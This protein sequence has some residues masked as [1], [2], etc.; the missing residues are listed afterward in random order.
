VALPRLSEQL[1]ASNSQLQWIVDGYTLVYAGL[2]LTSGSLGDRFGRKGAL[3]IGL[4]TFGI[5]SALSAFAT[6]TGMLIA[7][8]SLMGVGAALIMPGTLSIMTNIFTEPKERARAIGIWA[9]VAA[10]GVAIGPM[11][12]GFLIQHFWWGSVFLVNV[13]VVAVAFVAGR[14]ILPTSK[15]P[16][17]P[18]LDPIGAVLSIAALMTLLWGLIEAPTRGWGSTTIVGA[19]VAGFAML[20]CFIL[21]ELHSSHP[22][23][24][25]RFFRNRRFTAANIA[26][27][28]VFFALFGA[29]FLITQ[30]LQFVLGYSALKAGFALMPIALPMLVLGPI[31]ARIVEKLGTKVVVT[32]GLLLVSFGLFLLTM[33]NMG[34]GY[35]D[36]VIPMVILATGMGLTMAPATESIMGS[37]PRSKAGIGSAMNDTTR[38]MGGALGVAVIGSVL[39][40]VYRPHATAN[41]KHTV[42]AAHLHGQQA[43]QAHQAVDAIRDQIGAAYTVVDRAGLAHTAAGNQIIDA[44]R[45]A[46]VDGFGGAVM[47]GAVVA[48]LGALVT[49]AFLPARAP[50]ID[51]AAEGE[52]ERAEAL[53][54]AERTVEV[55]PVTV[56]VGQS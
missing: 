25:L 48:L 27:T 22:M 18:R 30:E 23:L 10:G 47:V 13:P 29:S 9:G 26:I 34:S 28:L 20:A 39:A 8:R 21:W 19:F 52:A 36:V 32:A 51:H 35:V 33:I 17:S 14:F 12:G 41:L 53:A 16:N 2:L 11:I 24:E 3:S 43:V 7:T 50:E 37:L 44:A 42:L 38:Q 40:S 1:N 6:S 15:D 49:L 31:S 5:G 45:H 56:S 46:F 55:A 54:E 4:A